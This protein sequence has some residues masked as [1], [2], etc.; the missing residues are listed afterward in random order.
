M[1]STDDE[2]SGPVLSSKAKGK[3][4]A[5]PDSDVEQSVETRS[6]TATGPPSTQ[7][8]LLAKRRRGVGLVTPNACNECRKKRVK[9]PH[10]ISI[11][12]RFVSTTGP[13]SFAHASCVTPRQ[14][15]GG[16]PCGRCRQQ[17]DVGCVYELPIR[18]SKED[19]RSEIEELR[20]RQHSSD[21]VI[22]ALGQDELWENVLQRLHNGETVDSISDWIDV[23]APTFERQSTHESKPTMSDATLP[24]FQPNIAASYPNPNT[25]NTI[26]PYIPFS[27]GLSA[28]SPGMPGP[29]GLS[30]IAG[31]PGPQQISSEQHQ[32]QQHQQQQQQQRQYQIHPHLQPQQIPNLL[33]Q[34]HLLQPDNPPWVYSASQGPS[35]LSDSHPDLSA[36]RRSRVSSWVENVSPSER[37][38]DTRART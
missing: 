3:Q 29:S 11:L 4:R 7:I 38:H 33:Q 9:V 16:R 5:E 37:F 2:L 25:G 17:R 12:Q 26:P 23:G 27:P 28:L 24:L 19:L 21:A 13:V 31:D 6:M 22:D 18:Q 8:Q 32:S 15:D 10:P 14:C 20:R 36:P 30:S 34:P 1:E 35:T